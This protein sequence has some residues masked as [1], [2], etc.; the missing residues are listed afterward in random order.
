MSIVDRA[1]GGS[2][3]R[4]DEARDKRVYHDTAGLERMALEQLGDRVLVLVVENLDRVFRDLGEQGQARLRNLTETSSKLLLLASTPLLFDAVSDHARPWYG[5]FDVE[6]LRELDA[7]EGCELLQ[8]IAVAAG[9]EDLAA[10]L[11][12]SDRSFAREGGRAPR[13]GITPNVDGARRVYQ[14]GVARRACATRRGA[15]RRVSAVLPAALMGARRSR[16]KARVR[17]VRYFR[18]DGQAGGPAVRGSRSEWPRRLSAAF[19]R[20][21]GASDEALWIRPTQHL[22]LAS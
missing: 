1:P 8:R 9:D 18:S 13:R 15:L 4:R 16:A 20:R 12:H 21:L 22:V 11:I 17:A 6:H 2:D 7:Q 3:D 19:T 5:S 14:C 10:S